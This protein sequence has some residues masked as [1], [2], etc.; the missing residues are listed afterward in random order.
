MNDSAGLQ[1]ILTTIASVPKD[2]DKATLLRTID[3]AVDGVIGNLKTLEGAQ[4]PPPL[5]KTTMTAL[6]FLEACTKLGDEQFRSHIKK[7]A[8]ELQHEFAVLSRLAAVVPPAN[9]A[10]G[11]EE[12]KPT[13]NSFE[14]AYADYFCK[15]LTSRL[16]CFWYDS[17]PKPFP[18]VLNRDFAPVLEE[19]VRKHVLPEILK[20]RRIRQLADSVMRD[21][22]TRSFFF[23]EFEKD[24]SENPTHV[25]WSGLMDDF[26]L[27]LTPQAP[28]P[29]KPKKVSLGLA[30]KP[31]PPPPK[32]TVAGDRVAK[33]EAFMG[34]LKK[35]AADKKF[36]VPQ[37]EDFVFFRALMDYKL[38]IVDENKR[39]LTQLL[40]QENL[41]DEEA[42]A[43]EGATRDW[44][45]RI[46][47]RLPP[48][49]GE[50]LALWAYHSHGELFTK[51]MLTSFMAGQGTTAEKRQRAVP[52]FSRW[53]RDII[54]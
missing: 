6:E 51:Q 44:L 14:P 43:R 4:V 31:P 50:L 15:F 52:M 41:E 46:V 47:D 26:R 30:K 18:Y 12:E 25:A 2:A 3:R 7:R 35:G 39:A 17:N 5:V 54:G 29:E 13:H 38:D 9:P 48:H 49:C 32:K 20:A 28:E 11:V 27:A 45:Y 53:M 16:S 21:N 37:V 10:S 33:A 40:R 34:V 22:F 23:A 24:P 42:K 19:A 1:D 8:I 36:D